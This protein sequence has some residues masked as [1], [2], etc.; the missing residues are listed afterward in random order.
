MAVKKYSLKKHG[1]KSCSAHTTVKEMASIGQGKTYSD[2]VL[3]DQGL[4]EKIEKL[5]AKLNCKKYIISSGYRTPAHD[6]A[7]GG[8]GKGYHTKGKA[9][10]AC[11]YHKN[12]KIIPAEIVCCVAQDLGFG[13]IANISKNRRYVH[14]DVRTGVKYKGDETVSLR[15]VTKDFYSYF[16]LT[17][18]DVAKY[19][20]EKLSDVKYYKK[21]TGKSLKVDYVLKG[22][23]VPLKYLGSPQKRKPIAQK[24][25]IKNYVGL[26]TQNL[27]LIYLAKKGKL[28]KV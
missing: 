28:K 4:M 17:K 5:F 21:Y 3:V 11:F 7:V 22:V 20:G 24:N 6:K 15:T 13:G 1:D 18:K 25:G 10:D 23:G 14:L 26:A 8:N 12:G 27:K 19:T 2:T 9:V 16:G